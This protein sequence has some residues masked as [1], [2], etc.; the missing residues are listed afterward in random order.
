MPID[1]A[2]GPRLELAYVSKDG[3]E[4]YLRTVTTKAVYT[5]TNDNEL[6]I[7]MQATTDKTTLVNM[8]HHSYVL[9]GHNSGTPRS[10]AD[11]SRRPAHAGARRWFPTVEPSGQGHTFRLHECESDRQGTHASGRFTDRLRPQLRRQWRPE[12][13]PSGG[14]A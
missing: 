4:G 5:L 10:R 11:A 2:E 14:P 12:S 13:V 6:K 3:E 1:T 9:S 7:E 8:A